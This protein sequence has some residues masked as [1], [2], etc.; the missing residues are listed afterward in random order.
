[1][2]RK[3]ISLLFPYYNISTVL[4]NRSA[5]TEVNG[6][7]RGSMPQNC[8]VLLKGS[9][10]HGRMLRTHYLV[11]AHDRVVYLI[12]CEPE[13]GDSLFALIRCHAQI[14]SDGGVDVREHAVASIS[15][16]CKPALHAMAAV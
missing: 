10:S 9:E 2:I 6:L 4:R 11:R 14:E 16:L 5:D 15:N 1:M 12:M 7:P 13:Y 3:T 8:E